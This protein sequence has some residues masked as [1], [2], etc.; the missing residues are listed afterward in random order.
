MSRL[1]RRVCSAGVVGLLAAQ[2]FAAPAY[3]QGTRGEQ[4]WLEDYG[5]TEA[6]ETTH[7]EG[8]TIAVIDTGVDGG[9]PALEGATVGGTDVSG[10]GDGSG[11]PVA[12]TNTEHGTL[13]ASLAAG[14]GE[15]LPQE[16][17]PE[18]FDDLSDEEWDDWFDDFLADL[19]EIYGE[20]WEDEVDE[21]VLDEFYETRVFPGMEEAEE[22]DSEA[23]DP[24]SLPWPERP[25]GVV[26]VAP[27]ADLLSV[28]LVLEDPNPHGPS[29][30]DQIAQAVRWAVD[31][32]ADIINMSIGSGT[33]DWPESWDE[34][35]LHAEQ[36]DVLVIAAAG[37]RAAGHWSVGAPATIPGVLTVAG[38]NQDRDISQESS[39][40][41]IAVDIAA[42]AEPLVGA[43]PEGGY[44]AW[45]GTSGATPIVAG[46]AALVMAA[47]PELSAQQ[48]KHR[49]L[50]SAD[51]AGAEGIDPEFG[52][53]VLNV[54]AAV[55]GSVPDF[56]A[57]DYDTLE[58]WIQV[59]RRS[60][61]ETQDAE[62]IPEDAGVVAG[63]EGEPRDLPQAAEV[64]S[65]QDWA[66]PVALGVS[67]LV[68]VALM[69]LAAV[70]LF[71]RRDN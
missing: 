71:S 54:D 17:E 19:E 69:T 28:S 9:H 57:A 16:M 39:S 70:H 38:V 23:L 5:V 34:A 18:D 47:H 3:G 50:T 64:R 65:S 43:L 37:N 24:E 14:R 11:G 35:F 12:Q 20:D 40:Q 53:G 22:D 13:V 58:D 42:A 62:G 30:D 48:V 21:D 8:V 55:N 31:N 46:A 68:L 36:N 67:A 66:G 7:G 2:L 32:G 10:G 63:P 56:N 45:T 15:E 27:E 44:G 60:E 51:S 61:A 29:T 4:F 49:L 1:G 41:G 25:A 6:W 33:Q 26:G 52:H 59:H